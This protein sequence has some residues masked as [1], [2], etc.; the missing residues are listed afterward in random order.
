MKQDGVLCSPHEGQYLS[1][2]GQCRAQTSPQ[3]RR[4]GVVPVLL[5]GYVAREASEGAGSE[6]LRREPVVK[7]EP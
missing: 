6:P 4:G 5:G 7:L 3:L 2:S 1:P